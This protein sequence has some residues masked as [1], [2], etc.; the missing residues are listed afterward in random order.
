MI[1]SFDLILCFSLVIISGILAGLTIGLMSL[2]ETNLQILAASGTESQKRNAKKIIPLRK[3]THLLLVTLL[4]GNTVVNEALPVVLGSVFSGGFKAILASTALIVI[5]GEIIPQSICARYGLEVGAFFYWPLTILQIIL[6]PLSYPISRILDKAL[7]SDRKM[8]YRKAELKELVN[9]NGTIYGGNLTIDEVTIIKGALDLSEKLVVDVMTRLENVYMLSYD[10]ILDEDLILEIVE[11][12]YSRIPVYNGTRE[13]IVGILLVKSLVLVNPS[14]RIP[15]NQVPIRK[16]PWISPEISLY[17]ILN[18]FQEGGCHMAIVTES[19]ASNS[20]DTEAEVKITIVDDDNQLST[21]LNQTPDSDS[22]NTLITGQ[23]PL[24][25]ITLE[26]VIEEL[27][28]EEIIDETDVFVDITN[29]VKVSRALSSV[30][31]SNA[32]PS[33]LKIPTS[34]GK[35]RYS[36]SGR[37]SPF[38]SSKRRCSQQLPEYPISKSYEVVTDG[39]GKSPNFMYIAGKTKSGEQQVF[40]NTQRNKQL[41]RSVLNEERTPLY[42]T[43]T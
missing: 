4:L 12:G 35:R 13:N 5:F 18:A 11:K 26:D 43:L 34:G 30:R 28:Q 25:V 41:A 17:E 38:I 14:D 8:L 9:L 1:S 20:V 15:V 23:I 36:N 40:E 39:T 3:N 27:I 2:D 33:S 7:G 31:I 22:K 16:I 21:S 29:R 6:Y 19:K 24:G 10:D 37:P 32:T 42:R